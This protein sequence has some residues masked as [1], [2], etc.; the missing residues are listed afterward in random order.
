MTTALTYDSLVTDIQQYAERTDQPFID[1]IPRF[2]M[3][4]ENRLATEV[5]GLGLLVVASFSTGINQS[6]YVKPARWRETKSL[7]VNGKYLFPRSYEYCRTYLIGNVP[8]SF[9]KYYSDYD[10]EHLFIVNKPDAVYSCEL[11]YYERPEPLSDSN[12]T[13]WITQYAPQLIIYS[14]LLEA[15]PF[16]KQS[17]RLQ[18]FSTLYEQAKAAITQE[19][20]DKLTDNAVSRRNK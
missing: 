10:Y 18:E 12:Q 1:Q 19:N 8:N 13:N 6:T 14:S 2:I 16:L 9:P 5:K 4:A 11:S 20:T 15:Q 3:L 17:N 7:T